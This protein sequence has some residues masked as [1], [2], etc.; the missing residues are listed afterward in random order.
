MTIV[1]AEAGINHNGS[2]T[3]ALEMIEVAVEAGADYIK[4]QTYV[5]ENL[6][7]QG[8]PKAPYQVRSSLGGE[9]QHGLLAE[10]RLTESEHVLVKEACD[11]KGIGFLSTAFDIA[12]ANFLI[13]SFNPDFLKIPSKC[14]IKTLLIQQEYVLSL[15]LLMGNALWLQIYLLMR[16]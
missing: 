11:A 16:T 1:I 15:L 14:F 10:C 13:D 6:L 3:K 5:T 8:A 9:T 4:F 2:V 12:S 7:R